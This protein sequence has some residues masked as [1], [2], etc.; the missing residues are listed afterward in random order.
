MGRI[1]TLGNNGLKENNR[2][3]GRTPDNVPIRA[4]RPRDIFDMRNASQTIYATDHKNMLNVGDEILS[5][6]I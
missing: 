1:Q 6:A 5:N 2:E 3:Y 4:S